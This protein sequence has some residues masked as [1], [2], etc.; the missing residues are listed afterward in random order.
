MAV[1]LR[2]QNFEPGRKAAVGRRLESQDSRRVRAGSSYRNHPKSLLH[3][4][5]GVQT[6]LTGPSG[7]C[8]LSSAIAIIVKVTREPME[9]K[10]P[11]RRQIDDHYFWSLIMLAV[12]AAA[13]LLVV[14]L[15]TKAL[16]VFLQEAPIP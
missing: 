2:S 7:L 16:F 3:P 9:E 1:V 13:F 11:L 5:G 4:T 12:T 14:W 6:I 15:A 10:R 8:E